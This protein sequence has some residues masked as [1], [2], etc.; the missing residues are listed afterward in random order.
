MMGGPRGLHSWLTSTA[1]G[2]KQIETGGTPKQQ[3]LRNPYGRK[4]GLE[5]TVAMF[6]VKG[7]FDSVIGVAIPTYF[8]C[9]LLCFWGRREEVL[10]DLLRLEIHLP[11]LR[12]C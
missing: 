3:I 9:V 5:T 7:G 8:D 1:P 10:Q 6:A 4:I 2:M 12:A 11:I